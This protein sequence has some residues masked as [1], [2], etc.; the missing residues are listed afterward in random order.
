MK[1]FCVAHL[2]PHDNFL[3]KSSVCTSMS[4][5]IQIGL[6]GK[7][8]PPAS[9]WSECGIWLWIWLTCEPYELMWELQ[10][11]P[12]WL[13]L[14]RGFMGSFVWV[15][16]K[17]TGLFIR[18]RPL[19]R[20]GDNERSNRRRRC[21][22]WVKGNQ[23]RILGWIL[24]TTLRGSLV[25]QTCWVYLEWHAIGLWFSARGICYTMTWQS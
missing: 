4:D 2:L 20:E 15:L 18:R 1:V 9:Q 25:L 24:P 3:S 7:G 12:M 14:W 19:G 21:Q 10:Y 13:Y 17:E 6:S 11:L 22:P 5:R 16:S 8:V 23:E